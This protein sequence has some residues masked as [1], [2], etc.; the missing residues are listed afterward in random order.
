MQK[1]TK[2]LYFA[3][4]GTPFKEDKEA[5]EAYDH[6]Y[7]KA[8]RMI[9]YGKVLFWTYK[10]EFFN[11]RLLTYKWNEKDKLCY[12]DWL[13]KQ[14]KNINCIQII[15]D[16][17]TPEFDE[18]WDMLCE[19]VNFGDSYEQHLYNSCETNDLIMFNPSTCRYENVSDMSRNVERI[20]QELDEAIPE[21][22]RKFMEGLC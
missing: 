4:D 3:D 8:Y 19:F 13:K 17:K 21:E 14:L 11:D 2:E 22:F 12:Y 1:I 10:G 15:A 20:K 16:T 5:C 7:H 6:V 9:C 18:I